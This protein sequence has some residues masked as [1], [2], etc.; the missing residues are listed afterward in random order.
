MKSIVKLFALLLI[1]Q[2]ISCVKE[3]KIPIPI[4]S[5]SIMGTSNETKV[6]SGKIENIDSV[7]STG[8][9]KSSG[10]TITSSDS[11]NFTIN[12][13][14]ASNNTIT[15]SIS[16]TQNS[17]NSSAPTSAGNSQTTS[18]VQSNQ[19][20]NSQPT[21]QVT[22]TVNGVST[23]NSQTILNISVNSVVTDANGVPIVGAVVIIT[24]P[25]NSNAILLQQVTDSAGKIS[26]IITI[27]NT[28]TQIEATITVAGQTTGAVPIIIKAEVKDSNG[29]VS[30]AITSNIGNIIIP[31]SISSPTSASANSSS[32]AS[33]GTTTSGNTSTGQTSSSTGSSIV[34]NANTGT[35][36]NTSSGTSVNN[37]YSDDDDCDED[38]DHSKNHKHEYSKNREHEDNDDRD[39]DGDRDHESDNEHHHKKHHHSENCNGNLNNNHPDKDKDGIE[40]SKDERPDDPKVSTKVRYPSSGVYTLAFEDS[41]PAIGDADY[42]DYVIQFYNEEYLNSKGQIIEIRGVYQHVAEGSSAIH[43]LNLRLPNG[44]DFTYETEVKD[45]RGNDVRE[46]VVKFTPRE[47]DMAD[48]LL[49]LGNSSRSLQAPHN[50]KKSAL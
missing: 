32:S 8:T 7:A 21:A 2:A 25:S 42:N 9:S 35:S 38:H 37:G 16:P 14:S 15:V 47:L 33:T 28:V 41:F 48:G 1:I 50:K 26:G 5:S 10:T 17:T 20:A 40:D 31:I 45:N 11:T 23:F 18:T 49:I 22:L 12:T 43:T 24:N 30:S 46:G 6:T 34:T 29:T 27:A 19:I 4:I 13:T 44:L 36:S 39:H 3:K